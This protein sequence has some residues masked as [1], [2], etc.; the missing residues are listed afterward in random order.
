MWRHCSAV[1]KMPDEQQE[2]Q[3]VEQPNVTL[4]GEQLSQ[5]VQDSGA[6][7]GTAAADAVAARLGDS[8]APT[9]TFPD[10]MTVTVSDDQWQELMDARQADSDYFRQQAQLS[11]SLGVF[12]LVLVAA[13]LGVL[14]SQVLMSRWA[15]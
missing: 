5:L 4:T 10:S 12:T 13:C 1:T 6:A 7:A 15:T 8:Q 3:P 2:Q 11:S 14:L 9:V